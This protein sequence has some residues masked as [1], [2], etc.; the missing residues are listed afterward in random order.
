MTEVA[1]VNF[2]SSENRESLLDVVL[3]KLNKAGK[4]AIFS[5]VIYVV[6]FSK[7]EQ[8]GDTIRG[9]SA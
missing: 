2:D 3:E 5:R 9:P 1:E 6:R 8:N 4:A 7:R